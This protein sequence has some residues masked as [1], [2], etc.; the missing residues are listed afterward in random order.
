M[1][2]TL[3]TYLTFIPPGSPHVGQTGFDGIV[4]K[5]TTS[6]PDRES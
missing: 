2:R 4:L 5:F 6:A 1:P 3:D